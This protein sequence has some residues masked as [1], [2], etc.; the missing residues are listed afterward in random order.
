VLGFEFRRW[1]P[2]FSKFKEIKVSEIELVDFVEGKVNRGLIV[3]LN[4]INYTPGTMKSDDE[5][6]IKLSNGRVFRHDKVG[7]RKEIKELLKHLNEK[8]TSN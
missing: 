4:L 6:L 8:T 5:L 3:L 7:S 1:I 2:V